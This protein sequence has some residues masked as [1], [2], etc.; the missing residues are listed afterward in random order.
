MLNKEKVILKRINSVLKRKY[1]TSVNQL[2]REY[3]EL[4]KVKKERGFTVGDQ[5]Y[6]SSSNDYLIIT[7]VLDKKTTGYDAVAK[8]SSLVEYFVD[9]DDGYYQK[10]K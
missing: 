6:D 8:N 3:E 7:R 2:L 4:S 1:G 5:I 9:F 10:V